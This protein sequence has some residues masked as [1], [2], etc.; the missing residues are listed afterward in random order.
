MSDH[1]FALPALDGANP[2]GYFA[3]LGLLQVG[4]RMNGRGAWRLSWARAVVS[5][6]TLHG[7]SSV[8]EIVRAVLDDRDLWRDSPALG[9]QG[10]DDVKFAEGD[11]RRYLRACRDVDDR[12][13]SLGLAS[14]LVAEG[15]TDNKGASKPTDFHFTAGQ[16]RFLN[17]ARLVR[18]GLDQRAVESALMR[19]WK[20]SSTLPSLKWDVGDDRPYALSA[21]DPAAAQK[22]TVPGA[23]WLAI[24]GLA[25]FPTF[26]SRR[27]IATTACSGSWKTGR[28]VW[29]L[30]S[31]PSGSAAVAS[32]VASAGSDHAAAAAW[33]CFRGLESRI[34]RSDQGGYGTF[35]PPRVIWDVDDE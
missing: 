19:A 28:F 6:P 31:S 11:C 15:A 14:A 26:L 22:L 8:D 1:S 25:F 23:E 29:P 4:D 17:M 7:P 9:W 2:L 5:T 18:D 10:C 24:N 12:G 20:P 33:G 32:Y 21:S 27:K 16:Q 34:R 3:A 35:S 13:R 30:W